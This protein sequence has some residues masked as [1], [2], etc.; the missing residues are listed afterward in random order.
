MHICVRIRLFLWGLLNQFKNVPVK[1]I[2]PGGL[3]LFLMF[4]LLGMQNTPDRGAWKADQPTRDEYVID[5]YFHD[6]TAMLT[7]EMTEEE[8]TID[9][10]GAVPS[11]SYAMQET[12]IVQGIL[13]ELDQC[14]F[15]ESIGE[16]D[17]LLL[18]TEPQDAIAQAR[19][20]LSF[21]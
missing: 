16:E 18:L 11:N 1:Q 5:Y 7:I 13:D 10:I 12:V 15:D 19:S 14:A 2:K 8:I 21:G 9:R 6:R 4:Y 17:R 3:R 20:A